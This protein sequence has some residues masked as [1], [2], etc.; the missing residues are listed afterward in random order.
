MLCIQ[1]RARS[2]LNLST[3]TTKGYQ[4]MRVKITHRSP[5]GKTEEPVRRLEPGGLRRAREV[6]G[7][8][9]SRGGMHRRDGRRDEVIIRKCRYKLK[10][11]YKFVFSGRAE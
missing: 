7:A 2:A 11:D 1:S 10:L 8:G 4:D 5:V 9:F 6:R 3:I